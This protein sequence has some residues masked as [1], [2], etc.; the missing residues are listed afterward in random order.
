MS[1]YYYPR[2]AHV[3]GVCFRRE[4]NT[5]TRDR[6]QSAVPFREHRSHGIRN[7]LLYGDTISRDIIPCCTFFSHRQTRVQRVSRSPD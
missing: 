3:A 2:R 5:I 4:K 1:H 7:V 6:C